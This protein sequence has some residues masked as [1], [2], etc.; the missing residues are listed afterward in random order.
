MVL[1]AVTCP[2]CQ[3]ER[4]TKRGDTDTG[5]QR[6]RCQNPDCPHPS[7]LLNPTYTGWR[8]CSRTC[9]NTNSTGMKQH[10]RVLA[11]SPVGHYGHPNVI[12][13]AAS[14]PDELLEAL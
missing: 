3:R 14:R 4:L 5:K 12:T 11:N 10:R 8:L 1:I 6:C 13:M 9:S 7:F 2:Y